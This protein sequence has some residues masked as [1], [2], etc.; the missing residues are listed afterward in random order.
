MEVIKTPLDGLLLVRPR[1]FKDD[2]G[3]F[4]E[5]YNRNAFLAAGISETFLQDNHSAS[6]RG[7]LRGLHFQTHPGQAKLI[8]CTAGRIWDVA[9]DI[10]PSSATFGR[11]FGVELAP[12]E[13]LQMFIPVGFA[14]GFLVLSDAAE[15]QYKCSNVYNASTESGIRWDDPDL[16]VAWPLGPEPPVLSE[17]D[18]KNQSFAA[19]RAGILGS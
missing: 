9:V 6:V 1:L 16:A 10:R 2:R 11:H 19:F 5:S 15:V 3:W 7:T 14:H 13:A 17:R 4:L 8:R 18:G 12:G